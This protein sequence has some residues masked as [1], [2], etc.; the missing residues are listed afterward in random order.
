M[1]LV[2]AKHKIVK[3]AFPVILF[4]LV[5]FRPLPS[6]A[7][8][9][10]LDWGEYFTDDYGAAP[11]YVS[12]QTLDHYRD[13]PYAFESGSDWGVWVDIAFQGVDAPADA[14]MT[15][16][17]SGLD[18]DKFDVSYVG[19]FKDVSNNVF[20]ETGVTTGDPGGHPV[21]K[22]WQGQIVNNGVR[23]VWYIKPKAGYSWED[24]TDHAFTLIGSMEA[25][26]SGGGFT[27]VAAVGQDFRFMIKDKV[28]NWAANEKAYSFESAVPA[29]TGGDI[30]YDDH[31]FGGGHFLAAPNSGAR[32]A[33]DFDTGTITF[34]AYAG[35]FEGIVGGSQLVRFNVSEDGK[36][37]Y[38]IQFN[39]GNGMVEQYDTLYKVVDGVSTVLAEDR[40]SKYSFRHIQIDR[41]SDGRIIVL[42]DGEKLFDVNDTTNFYSGDVIF[43]SPTWQ[44]MALDNVNIQSAVVTPEPASMLLFGIGGA[45]MALGRLRRK[46]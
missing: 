3:Q 34:D 27:A 36:S 24:D 18:T 29:L 35:T 14:T 17:L 46:V 21:Y 40:A 9:M 39:R 26:Q 33:E 25:S 43:S 28:Y 5:L 31:L 6:F 22:E 30:Q 1:R 32:F 41:Q 38:L 11:F 45:A 23:P 42:R 20:S 12:N 13:K 37:Y 4:C 8:G 44:A 15:S 16:Y 19:D 7:G 2:S 10:I